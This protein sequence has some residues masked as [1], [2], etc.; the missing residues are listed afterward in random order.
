MK[1]IILVAVMFVF[2]WAGYAQTQASAGAK[3]PEERATMFTD[4][5][6]KTVKLT[7]DQKTKVQ[8]V[9]VKVCADETGCAVQKT[10]PATG[11]QG[12]KT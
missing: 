2:T 10:P 11:R 4:W 3:T 1:K 7:P 8:A 12:A 6:D 9:N 5:I